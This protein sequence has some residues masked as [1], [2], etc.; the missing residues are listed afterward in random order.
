MTPV[1]GRR[2]LCTQMC[3]HDLGRGTNMVPDSA[4]AF[5]DK[6]RQL[7]ARRGLSLRQLAAIVHHGKS[8]LHELETGRK[9]PTAAVARRL[10]A[11]LEAAGSLAD[12]ICPV[13]PTGEERRRPI[14][15]VM[16]PGEP[17]GERDVEQLHETVRQLVML[18]TV[19]GSEGLYSTAVRAF[20]NA[21]RRMSTSGVRTGLLGDIHAAV[22]EVG[23][24]AAWLAYDSER[25]QISRQVANEAMLIAQLA[26]DTSMHRFLLSHLSMQATYQGRGAEGL[27]I[28]DRTLAENPRSGRVVGMM[29]VRRARALGQLGDSG[30][31][32]AELERASNQLADGVGPDDPP[33]TWWLHTAELAVHEARIRAAGGDARGAV[34]ASERSVLHLPAG[35]GRDQALYR[36]WLIVDLIGVQAW[37]DGDRVIA[38]LMIKAPTVGSARVPRILRS[39][40]GQAARAGAPSWF[41]DALRE[42]AEVSDPAA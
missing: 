5:A 3:T 20:R 26:G 34:T 14:E 17:M 6:L 39:A 41:R 16:P 38:D 31:A 9:P 29:R 33:W 40:D 28:A 4:S 35:Q 10:D 32:L 30:Q 2:P 8:Y 37:R 36:A 27:A 18:D 19:H 21:H 23:E 25:Q 1:D 15:P 42:A 13:E 24:V 22:A 11:A 7:R 12:L